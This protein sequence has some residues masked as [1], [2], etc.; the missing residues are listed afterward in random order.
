M[1][2]AHF[3][4]RTHRKEYIGDGVYAAFDGY[5][6]WLAAERDGRVHNIAIEPEVWASLK[7]Y[8]HT[9]WGEKA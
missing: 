3:D 8:A 4:D 5:Q 1:T 9:I 6:I 7:A 2:M